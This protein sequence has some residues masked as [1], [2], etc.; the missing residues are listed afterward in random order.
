MEEGVLGYGCR[1]SGGDEGRWRGGAVRRYTH[2]HVPPSPTSF[3]VFAVVSFLISLCV[4]VFFL[5]SVFCALD[6]RIYTVRL[7]PWVWMGILWMKG[8]TYSRLA[9][10]DA[11]LYGCTSS[12][13]LCLCALVLSCGTR[14]AGQRWTVSSLFL[15]WLPTRHLWRD[16]LLPPCTHGCTR[17]HAFVISTTRI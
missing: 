12:Q 5:C 13:R 11:S 6:A 2:T 8:G 15:P 14:C 4:C 7:S 16:A 10:M 3:G 9:C 1:G 17:T